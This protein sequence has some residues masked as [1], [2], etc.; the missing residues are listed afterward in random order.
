MSPITAEDR[1]STIY[2]PLTA[3]PAGNHHLL[4]VESVLQQLPETKLV[5]FLLSNGLHPDPFKH[6]KIPHAVLRLE[7]LRSALA[8]WTDPEKSLPAHIRSEEH[9]SELQSQ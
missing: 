7:I 6:Q 1:L 8:D 5:V 3:N 4:L 2:F 9:T